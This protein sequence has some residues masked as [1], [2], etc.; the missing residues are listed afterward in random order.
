M[1][2]KNRDQQQQQVAH[3]HLANQANKRPLL[4]SRGSTGPS[5]HQRR[6]SFGQQ[7]SGHSSLSSQTSG[8]GGDPLLQRRRRDT[9]RGSASGSSRPAPA[10]ATATLGRQQSS[11][12][13]R[14]T[15]LESSKENNTFNYDSNDEQQRQQRE[16]ECSLP[17][18]SADYERIRNET[19]LFFLDRLYLASTEGKEARTLH[20]L[21]CLFGTREFTREMR[22]IVGASRNGLKK[23]LQS[24]PSLFQIEEDK[25]YLTQ[26]KEETKAPKRD[27]NQEAVEYFKQKLTQ[28]GTSLVPIKNLFGYRSQASHEVRHVSGKSSRDFRHFLKANQSTFELWADGEHVMLRSVL[29][30]LREQ[31]KADTSGGCNSLLSL[32]MQQLLEKAQHMQQ[33]QQ[34]NQHR[35]SLSSNCSGELCRPAGERPQSSSGSNEQL[36]GD[37]VVAMDPYLNKR[38]AHLIEQC[39]RKKKFRT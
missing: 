39:L 31:S 7:R 18:S 1:S 28:F 12:D 34:S 37:D 19:V 15:M 30:E 21:S 25:V 3:G 23:F 22:Q 35:D 10:A 27:Y 5:A 6:A 32:Q 8:P 14:Q 2:T 20:E 33:Q 24:F 9:R 29:E 36:A 38:F 13:E 17:S 4:S 11:L 16:D 26:L